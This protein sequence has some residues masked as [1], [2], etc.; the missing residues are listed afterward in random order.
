LQDIF[1]MDAQIG[2]AGYPDGFQDSQEINRDGGLELHPL[3]PG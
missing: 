2:A 3:F 1:L